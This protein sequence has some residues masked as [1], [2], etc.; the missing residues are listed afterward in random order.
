[1]IINQNNDT[2]TYCVK[3]IQFPLQFSG[4]KF[5]CILHKELEFKELFSYERLH[6]RPL[7]KTLNIAADY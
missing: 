4:L 1:M 7:L 3:N 6:I 5:Y 2:T